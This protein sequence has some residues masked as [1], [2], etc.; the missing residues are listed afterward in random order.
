MESNPKMIHKMQRM[1]I[2]HIVILTVLVLST[3]MLCSALT[4]ADTSGNVTLS[5]GQSF[6]VMGTTE[7]GFTNSR[8]YQMTALDA[9]NPMPGGKNGGSYT[10]T[11]SG[12]EEHI[13]T[14]SGDG[15]T[16][17]E[18]ALYF[19]HAGVYEY[20][21]EPLT[22]APSEKYTYEDTK[23]TVRIYVKNNPVK[24]GDLIVEKIVCENNKG[25]KPDYIR[26]HCSYKGAPAEPEGDKDSD[27]GTVTKTGDTSNLVM[28]SVTFAFVTSML[29]FLLLRRRRENNKNRS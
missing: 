10:F 25:E 13:F 1:H 14:T 12:D 15:G 26:Y 17:S 29:L 20:T 23:Y 8:D 11:L 19:A 6:N 21:V 27:R 5:V 9:A 4:Y 28:W 22:K 7:A 24:A 18:P 2:G 16:V 3:V